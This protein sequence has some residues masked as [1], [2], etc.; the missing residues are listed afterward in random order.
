MIG[1]MAELPVPPEIQQAAQAEAAKNATAK[2]GRA[3][4]LP[5]DGAKVEK[6]KTTGWKEVAVMYAIVRAILPDVAQARTG[7]F[8]ARHSF[9]RLRRRCSLSAHPGPNGECSACWLCPP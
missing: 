6:S 5:T 4:A 2:S 8:D 7:R 1:N 3:D 9:G